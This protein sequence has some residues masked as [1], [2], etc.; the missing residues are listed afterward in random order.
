MFGLLVEEQKGKP[1]LLKNPMSSI[2]PDPDLRLWAAII[3]YEKRFLL[4]KK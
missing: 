1:K 3:V 2:R 4:R